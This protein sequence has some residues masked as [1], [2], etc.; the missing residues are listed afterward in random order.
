MR[1]PLAAIFFTIAGFIFFA[2]FSVMTFLQESVADALTD[3]LGGLTASSQTS[4]T[5]TLTLI[6]T[7]F[8]VFAVVFFLVAVVLVF[9]IDS[10]RDDPEYYY[11][12]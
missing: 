10:W 12:P 2:I 1:F 9:F 8:G 4:V 3:H 6:Q 5:N 7:G 11:R